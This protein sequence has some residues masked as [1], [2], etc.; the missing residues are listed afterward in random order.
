LVIVSH[1]AYYL[2][3]HCERACVLS[4]GLLHHFEKVE[5]ALG[6]HQELMA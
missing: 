6:Y 1:D 2:Q 5:D 3:N 4:G